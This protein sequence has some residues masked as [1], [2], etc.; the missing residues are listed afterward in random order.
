M[1]VLLCISVALMLARIQIEEMKLRESPDYREYC[2]RVRY[3]LVPG[4]Y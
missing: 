4:L 1:L 3:R 2:V